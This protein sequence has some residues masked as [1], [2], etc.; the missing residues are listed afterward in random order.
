MPA[1]S[2]IAEPTVTLAPL[3]AWTEAATA[4]TVAWVGASAILLFQ[5]SHSG[6]LNTSHERIRVLVL[7]FAKSGARTFANACRW[8]ASLIQP[9]G[10]AVGALKSTRSR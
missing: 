10:T 8:V 4:L 1:P 9:D 7:Y 6:S 2:S 5:I 3:L